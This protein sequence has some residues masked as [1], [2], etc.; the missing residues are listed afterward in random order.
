MQIPQNCQTFFAAATTFA[1][2]K[3][4]K[5]SKSMC[6]KRFS[7]A[8]ILD[9]TIWART[10]ECDSTASCCSLCSFS[11]DYDAAVMRFYV[12][13]IKRLVASFFVLFSRGFMC[14]ARCLLTHRFIII[15]RNNI[16]PFVWAEGGTK[17]CFHP[18]PAI[19]GCTLIV[20]TR[21]L[22]QIASFS[23]FDEPEGEFS[24]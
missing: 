6:W 14:Q 17:I 20:L 2:S 22:E 9:M 24:E 18:R 15:S 10:A 16:R 21:L 13:N 12:M 5:F 11:D 4:Y 19:F 8:P 3:N 7:E 1:N 23:V